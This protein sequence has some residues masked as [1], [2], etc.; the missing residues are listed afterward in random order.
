MTPYT[1]SEN[2]QVDIAM[3]QLEDFGVPCDCPRCISA[4]YRL[5]RIQQEKEERD[6]R[7]PSRDF[8]LY[9]QEFTL[10]Y[11]YIDCLREETEILQLMLC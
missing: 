8:V 6:L 7:R 2:H 5:Q 4:Y 9:N 10:E 1:W 11:S 3:R